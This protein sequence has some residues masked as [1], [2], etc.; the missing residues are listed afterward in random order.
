VEVE[1]EYIEKAQHGDHAAFEELVRLYER[2]VYT[3][4]FRVI[5]NEH[6]A[7]D[8]SQ[9]VFLRLFRTISSFRGNSA[10]STWLFRLTRNICL[11]Q[12]NKV[13]RRSSREISINAQETEEGERVMEIP[14][15][16][17]RPDAEL[18]KAVLKEQIHEALATLS[19]EHR[20]VLTL[21]ELNGLTYAEI[22]TELKLEIGTVKSQIAR[23]REQLKRKL[24][25]KG[26]YD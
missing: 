15:D 22:A 6:D 11:D 24:I 14:D 13:K 10:F 9:E 25:D 1:N 17:H 20:M 8:I 3:W 21:R 7:M 5:G 2:R 26:T 16:S 18:D 19:V 12:L 4:A 23:A